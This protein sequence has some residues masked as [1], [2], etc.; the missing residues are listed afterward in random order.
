M[1]FF[2][3]GDQTVVLNW[4]HELRSS[5]NPTPDGARNFTNRPLLIVPPWYLFHKSLP[6]QTLVFPQD[7]VHG[8]SHGPFLL[9]YV[10][11]S[12]RE[13]KFMFAICCRP[14]LCLSSVCNA[15]APY[16]IGW[17]FP[18][19]FYATWY[20]GHPLTSTENFTEIVLGKPPSAEL[21]ARGVAKYSDFGAVG[22]Y[23]SETV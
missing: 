13:L 23:I 7:W 8:P 6:P 10:G 1:S 16:S 9:R 3:T 15:R 22:G 5:H 17:N 19:I 21:N 20:L 4:V 18:Q 11:S 12:E 14:S 2:C